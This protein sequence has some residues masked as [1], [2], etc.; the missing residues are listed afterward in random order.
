MALGKTTE[1]GDEVRD[2]AGDY[3]RALL[4]E[5]NGYRSDGRD[6]RAEAVAES[7]RHLGY[8][9][10]PVKAP[11]AAPVVEEVVAEPVAP[12]PAEE[13]KE[14]AAAAEPLETAVEKPRRGR[15]PKGDN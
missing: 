1:P 2:E 10:E 11:E 3:T 4:I 15:P 14:T 7:L 6:E 9:V 13:P 8:E 12:E 5:Y